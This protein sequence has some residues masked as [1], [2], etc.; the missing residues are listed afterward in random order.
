MTVDTRGARTNPL[1]SFVLKRFLVIPAALL[2]LVTLTFL[3]VSLIPGDPA[4]MILGDNATPQQV[5]KVHTELGLD[6]TWLHRYLSYF[7]A[8]LHGNLGVSFSTGRSVRAQI[9]SLLPNSLVLIIPGIAAAV[10]IGT[11]IGGTAAYFRR[12]LA[13]RALSVVITSTQSVP[14]FFIGGLMILVFYFALH[15]APAPVGAL[16]TGDVPHRHVTGSL[17]L[18]AVL[19]GSG[20]AVLSIAAHAVLPVLTLGIFWSSYFAKTVRNSMTQSLASPH[21]EFARAIGLRERTAIG[22]AFHSARTPI[23]TYAAILFGSLLGGDAIIERVFAWPGVGSWALDGVLNNDVPVVQ[24][25]VLCVGIL[26]LF[27]YLALD[28]VVMVLD[29]RVRIG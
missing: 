18:D 16:G 25:F 20:H 6:H 27:V 7:G 3:L 26:T 4:Y 13:D 14:D 17:V 21:V 19:T 8:V 1:W 24:G 10:L 2:A 11:V 23:L 28:V 12:R 22:Y 5:A 9:L 29:P 15:F